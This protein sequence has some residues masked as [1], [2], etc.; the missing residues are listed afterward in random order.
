[1]RPNPYIG[2]RPFQTGEPLY[3]REREASALLDLLINERVVLLYSPS[4]AGK[5]SLINSAILPQLVQEGFRILGPVRVGIE[6]SSGGAPG[7]P[8][9][10]PGNRY[11]YSL[12]LSLED[13]KPDEERVSQDRLANMTLTDYVHHLPDRPTWCQGDVWVLDQLEEILTV[14]QFDLDIKAEFFG[15]MG[16]VLRGPGNW[17]LFSMREEFIAGVDPYLRYI[18]GGLSTRFRLEPLGAEA[19][20]EYVTRSA[21]AYGVAFTERAADSLINELRSVA[22]RGTDGS[23]GLRLAPYLDPVQLQLVCMRLWNALPPDR[24]VIDERDVE[25]LGDLDHTLGNYYDSTVSNTS[26]STGVS[27]GAIR[28]WID[29]ELISAAG[30]RTSVLREPESSQGLDNRAIASMVDAHLLRIEARGGN[31]WYELAHDRLLSPVRVS[32]QAWFEVNLSV[33]QRQAALWE[34]MS[35]PNSL[36]FLEEELA[37]GEAWASTHADELGHSEREFLDSSRSAQAERERER[38]QSRRNRRLAVGAVA[39]AILALAGVAAATVF[40]SAANSQRAAAEAAGARAIVERVTANVAS[41]RAVMG[42]AIANA[43][44]TRAVEGQE[45]AQAANA[46]AVAALQTLEV[47]LEASLATNLTAQAQ[48]IPPPTPASAITPGS[49]LSQ[50]PTVSA[51]GTRPGV[52]VPCCTVAPSPTPNTTVIAQ[53]TQLAQVRATQTQL[54]Y[55]PGPLLF[56]SRRLGG[57]SRLFQLYAP[58]SGDPPV[59]LSDTKAFR[60]SVDVQA[61][62]NIVVF[63]TANRP[64]PGG[65]L[66]R[67]LAAEQLTEIPILGAGDSRWDPAISPDGSSVLFAS[68]STGNEDIYLMNLDGSNVRNLTSSPG[69]DENAPAWSPDGMQVAFAAN[70][71]GGQTDIWVM[72]IDGTGLKR[73]TDHQSV[74]T[75][76]AWSPDG[77]SIAFASNRDDPANRHPD[78]YVLNLQ[79]GQV[80]DLT[81]TPGVDENF[82]AWSRDGTWLAFTRF[83]TN[84]EIFIMPSAGGAAQNV[85][86]NPTEDSYPAWW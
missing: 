24:D 23:T 50:T 32:N 15:Q 29:R 54:A 77:A 39:L 25:G 62:G 36:L 3:G 63:S 5:S 84:G 19:A 27:E 20:R 49:T 17:A 76:P 43:A 64:Q 47:S 21:A 56:V 73:L 12:L 59:L 41:T 37:R 35:R 74:D 48:T 42:E 51:Q 2:P 86:N 65:Q 30:T 11:V 81:N 6:P 8:G 38:Q 71:A 4:G 10:E 67:I 40:A 58:G 75:Y 22:T 68:A 78:I 14:D 79:T 7:L 85:T 70:P 26:R 33:L 46:A 52:V 34:Q 72:N 80:T 61:R 13:R 53:R 55:P 28:G 83:T 18:P 16:E 57:T 31:L 60:P 1:M 9:A 69:I 66:V 82:P 44:S 45:S